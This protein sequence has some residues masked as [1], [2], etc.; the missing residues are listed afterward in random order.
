MYFVSNCQLH[1][2]ESFH[3]VATKDFRVTLKKIKIYYF[4]SK[5]LVYIDADKMGATSQSDHGYT[6]PIFSYV[7]IGENKKKLVICTDST[8]YYVLILL[9]TIQ[10]SQVANHQFRHTVTLNV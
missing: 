5:V 3:T 2:L 7:F 8:Y 1:P 4:I 6:I 10:G 9:A